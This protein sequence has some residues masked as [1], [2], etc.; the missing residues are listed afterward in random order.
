MKVGRTVGIIVVGVGLLERGVNE[1]S[2]IRLVKEVREVN[3]ASGKMYQG[4]TG[5]EREGSTRSFADK[6]LAALPMRQRQL[7]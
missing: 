2:R 4:N 7:T 6:S 3:I 1:T 5:L